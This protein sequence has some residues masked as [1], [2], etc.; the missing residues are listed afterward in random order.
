MNMGV[1]SKF[2][3]T[4]TLLVINIAVFIG[5]IVTGGSLES[6]SHEQVMRWGANNG[7]FTIGGEYWRLITAGFVHANILHIA[8]NMWGLWNLGHLSER[9]FG[10]WQTAAIYL[11]TGIGGALLSIAYDHHR[12]EVGASG[13]IFGIAGAILVGIKFGDVTM[14]AAEKRATIS[15]LV[16]VI[17]LNFGM[18]MSGNIDNICHLG[19]FIT[20]LM[21]GLPLGAFRPR[22]TIRSTASRSTG[23]S[24]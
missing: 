13:A 23:S 3:A 18:G 21:V 20:G 16:L 24:V 6:F 7:P 19:G 15:S 1:V 11:L 14:S 22:A 8:F 5:M 4:T 10:K 2:P 9:L 12:S 17:I